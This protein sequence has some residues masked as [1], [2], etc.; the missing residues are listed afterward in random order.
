MEYV[1]LL[2]TEDV[3]RAAINMQAAAERMQSAACS[4]S[5]SIRSIKE[6][7]DTFLIELERIQGGD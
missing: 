4:I 5:D 7:G 6:Y 1:Q 2:G 3:S